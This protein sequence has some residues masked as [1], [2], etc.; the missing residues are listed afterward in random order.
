MNPCSSLSLAVFRS[1]SLLRSTGSAAVNQPEKDGKR[2]ISWRQL[3]VEEEEEEEGKNQ[4]RNEKAG[5]TSI[6]PSVCFVLD[7]MYSEHSETSKQ[8]RTN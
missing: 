3:R 1:L 7:P 2:L 8:A 4:V 6:A 5:A